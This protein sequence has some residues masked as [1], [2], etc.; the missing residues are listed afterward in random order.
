MRILVE[1]SGGYA[2]I[3]RKAEVDSESLS[4]PESAELQSL[5]D[6]AGIFDL[7]AAPSGSSRGADQ[8][9]YNVNIESGERRRSVELRDPQENVKRLL[10]WVWAHKK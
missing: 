8:F 7:P 1:R 10:D 9:Q 5:V 4:K 2:G 6:A 3:N